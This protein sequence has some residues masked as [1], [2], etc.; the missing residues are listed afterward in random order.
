ML[1]NFNAKLLNS[2]T[3]AQNNVEDEDDGWVYPVGHT[4]QPYMVE[5]MCFFHGGVEYAADTVFERERLLEIRPNDIKRYLT[6]KAYKDPHPNIVGGARPIHARSDS[7][8]YM[9]KALSRYMPYRTANWVNGQGNPTKSDIV[10][11]MI[12]EVKKFEVRGEGAPS[13][14]KRPLKQSEF[15]KTL[16]LF[17][18]QGDWN[19]R[20]RYPMMCLWQFNLI[21]RVDDVVHFKLTDPRG[22]NDF[23]FA[24]KTKVRWSKNVMEERQCPP[25]I[26]LG[27]MDPLFCIHL[28]LGLYLEETLSRNPDQ[29]Y[30]FTDATGNNAA[31][32]LKQTYR[33][34][35]ERV[36]WSQDEFTA[37][38]TEEDEEGVGTHSYRKFPSNYAR[39][40]GCSPDEIEIR[41]RW[42]TQGQ[43]V[44]FRYIDV[45]QLSID[46]K[47]AGVLSVGGPIKYKFNDGVNLTDDWLFENVVPNTRRR[48][49]NDTRLCRVLA[50]SILFAALDNEVGE[51]Y[52]P[53]PMR[54]RITAAYIPT[55]P[56]IAQPVIRVPLT[57]Y[58]IQDTLMIDEMTAGETE[59]APEAGGAAPVGFNNQQVQQ[60]L[61]NLQSL[62]RSVAENHQQ[63]TQSV[64]SLRTWT[65]QQFRTVNTNIRS[66]GGT[67]QG[68]LA[69]QDPQQQ[70]RRRQATDPERQVE[71]EGTLPATLSPTPRTLAELWE[72]YQFGIGGRKPAKDWTATERG[73]RIHG[74]K[75]KYYRRK[76]VWWTMEE[77][78]RRGDTRNTAI[79]KI[80]T[81]YGWRCS[82]TQII[83]FLIHDHGGERTGHANLVDLTPR[84]QRGGRR[85]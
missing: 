63:M 23:D 80:R 79:N 13:N 7:L 36:V 56:N 75:Q 20:W 60:L 35:L 69:R 26:L 52:V 50:K 1:T 53:G 14:A 43:R 57:I 55:H 38:A 68:A 45:K 17:R 34:R 73:N 59:P 77:L 44:V 30:L 82:V 24:L 49:P 85:R 11:D 15:R 16:S 66:F 61:I 48:F 41:G 76:F 71:Q 21:G 6:M 51:E 18:A 78:I 19:H 32:N 64:S 8:Y 40:C 67:I 42:K 37:L 27:S 47:V 62:Q 72:E 5:F 33:K 4:Y 10:N 70:A 84:L 46:A 58:R 54:D 31:V 2:T 39:G 9:K 74:I 12:K 3:M 29:V 22:H 65:Q 83:N 28:N 81:A 25:Q